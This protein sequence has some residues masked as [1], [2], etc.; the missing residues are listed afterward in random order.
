MGFQVRVRLSALAI[1]S[2]GGLAEK[3]E[4]CADL[5]VQRLA[6]PSLHNS[7]SESV[8]SDCSQATQARLVPH[9]LVRAQRRER[10]QRQAAQPHRGVDQDAAG[11]QQEAGAQPGG[12]AGN[13]QD[14]V[15]DACVPRARTVRS[16]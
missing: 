2:D 8:T 9:G 6:V 15:Q 10:D 14:D 16:S 1:P 12:Q 13:A 4:M 3:S 7:D 11:S 5:A